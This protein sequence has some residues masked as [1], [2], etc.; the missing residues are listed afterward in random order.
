[1][2]S[3]ALCEP[4]DAGVVVTRVPSLPNTSGLDLQAILVHVEP[5]AF[6]SIS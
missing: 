5:S 4:N 2:K 6:D 3:W 1:M